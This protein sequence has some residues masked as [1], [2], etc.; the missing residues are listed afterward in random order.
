MEGIIIII[1]IFDVIHASLISRLEKSVFFLLFFLFSFYFFFLFKILLKAYRIG[2]GPRDSN[3]GIFLFRDPY[4]LTC[5]AKEYN[6]ISDNNGER[7]FN[8]H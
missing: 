5:I 1:I 6:E 3:G 2:I 7:R 4:R 8:K